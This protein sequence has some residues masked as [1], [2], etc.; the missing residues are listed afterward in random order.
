M[1]TRNLI[2][3]NYS[4]RIGKTFKALDPS[5]GKDLEGDFYAAS[6]LEADEALLLADKAFGEFR[7]TDRN[8]RAAFLRSAADEITALGD[9]LIERA[10]A[11]TGLPAARL[12]GERARTT[13][14]LY[15]FAALLEEGS[16]VEAIIDTAIPDRK[17]LPRVDLRKMM[18]PIGPVVV[19]GAS[20]FPLAYSVAGGDTA[21]ALASGCP[22]AIAR[23]LYLPDM[24]M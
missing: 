12:Q 5:T 13:G 10:M 20:N 1:D 15:M 24:P 8:K 11:E 23:F 21:A 2:G 3:Y 17:P 14:Q 4:L 19:F 16:W 9:E 7:Y 18:V 6:L 22:V